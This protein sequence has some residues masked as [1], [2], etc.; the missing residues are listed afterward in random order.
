LRHGQLDQLLPR[1]KSDE[2]CLVGLFDIVSPDGHDHVKYVFIVQVP[3]HLIEPLIKNHSNGQMNIAVTFPEA[4]FEFPRQYF[5]KNS[6]RNWTL[7]GANQTLLLSH[8]W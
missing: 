4:F 7:D 1:T 6:D 5:S 3:L 8:Q 2:L